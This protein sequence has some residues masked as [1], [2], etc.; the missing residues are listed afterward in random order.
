MVCDVEHIQH[1]ISKDFLLTVKH[2]HV[3]LLLGTWLL[4]HLERSTSRAHS[5]E[6]RR[7]ANPDVTTSSP[8]I[9]LGI[10]LFLTVARSWQIQDRRLGKWLKTQVS[11]HGGQH[12]T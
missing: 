8:A 1:N 9:G 11:K 10:R 5:R 2:I 3:Y 7:L 12:R 6:P 4:T